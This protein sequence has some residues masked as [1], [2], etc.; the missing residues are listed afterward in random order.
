MPRHILCA[1]DSATVQRVIEI[2]L[3]REDAFITMVASADEALAAARRE[4]PD[5]VLADLVMPGRSGYELCAALKADGALREVPVLMLSSN[6]NLYDEAR[7]RSVGAAGHILKP[8]ETQAFIDKVHELL[9]G[10][11]IQA[12]AAAAGPKPVQPARQPAGRS[13]APPAPAASPGPPAGARPTPLPQPPPGLGRPPA[14]AKPVLG[15][16]PMIGGA[17]MA[18]RSAPA[19][20]PAAVVPAPT[21][22]S[23]TALGMSAPS[24]PPARVATP[25]QAPPPAAASLRPPA[26]AAAPA[27]T[28]IPAAARAVAAERAAEKMA[29]LAASGPEYAAIAQLSR[30]IIEQIAWEVV[31]ELA[32]AII[33]SELERLMQNKKP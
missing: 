15:R 26:S 21:T 19:S 33:R 1:D 8:F 29:H 31:P 6:F 5:L 14:V 11:P 28:A 27:S 32:E 20:A 9:S 10:V 13:P 22:M 12:R 18:A 2:T 23:K 24:F 3:A 7:G 4:R 16:P 17:Q 25:F 30:E